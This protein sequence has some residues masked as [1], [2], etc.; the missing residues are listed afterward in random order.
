MERSVLFKNPH[1][2]RIFENS[3]FLSEKPE[4]INEISFSQ[5]S[6]VE[7]H[8]LFCGDAAGMITPLCGNGMA[9]A[10][11]SCRLVAEC[12]IEN[13]RSLNIQKRMQLESRYRNT[14]QSHFAWRVRKGRFIQNV[15]LNKHVNDLAFR[16]LNASPNLTNRIVRGTH[17]NPF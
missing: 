16:I 17:G 1:L 6:L 15:F 4:V 8:I 13:G 10:I 7:D 12:I 2:K 11:H 5:K 9:M 14:W 3:E